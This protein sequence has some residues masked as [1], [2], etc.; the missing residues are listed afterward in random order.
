MWDATPKNQYNTYEGES[1]MKRICG[2]ILVVTFTIALVLSGYVS[3]NAAY[4]S[5]DKEQLNRTSIV[6]FINKSKTGLVSMTTRGTATIRVCN[7]TAAPKF[8]SSDKKIATI[9]SSGKVQAVKAGKCKMTV[10]VGSK[11]YTCKVTVKNNYSDKTLK[12]NMKVTAKKKGSVVEYKIVNKFS[13]P[14]NDPVQ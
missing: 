9:D 3:T 10:T 7:S 2:I 12:K 4:K 14:M 13:H 5:Y 8:K 6:L 11:K 1:N